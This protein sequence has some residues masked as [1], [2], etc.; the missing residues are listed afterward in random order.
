M[1]DRAILR[2][3]DLPSSLGR[4]RV[5]LERLTEMTAKLFGRVLMGL[6][7]SSNNCGAGPISNGSVGISLPPNER[8]LH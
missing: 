4:S 1:S 5:Y 7:L 3:P 8:S 2:M 6:K